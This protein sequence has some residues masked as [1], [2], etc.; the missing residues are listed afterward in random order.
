M[1]GD[2]EGDLSHRL[3]RNNLSKGPANV[4]P[5]AGLR[6]I[7]RAARVIAIVV[8]VKLLAAGLTRLTQKGE[9]DIDDSPASGSF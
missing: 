9:F 6:E 8:N 7:E 5:L 1:V 4:G 3:K 2:D